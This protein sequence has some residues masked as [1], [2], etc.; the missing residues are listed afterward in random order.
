MTIARA[1]I[2]KRADVPDGAER[3]AGMERE[4]PARARIARKA[5][6]D[7]ATRAADLVAAAE[8]RAREIVAAAERAAAEHQLRAEE[9]AR[10][11]AAASVA[12]RVVRLADLEARV[13]ERGLDRAIGLARVLAERLL[14]AE[15]AASPERILDLARQALAETRGAKR[16]VVAAHPED[17]KVLS[18]DL[19][20]LGVDPAAIEIRGDASRARGSLRLETEVGVLD[21][22]LAPQLERLAEKLRDSMKADVR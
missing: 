19:D 2:I 16:V 6:V 1:R 21:A 7:A 13:D 5:V 3:I 12:D 4:A 14:G 10:A 20:R 17:A 18:A 8:R 11:D 15:L 22:E 9:H